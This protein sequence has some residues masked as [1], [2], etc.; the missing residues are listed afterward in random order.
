MARKP[1][2]APPPKAGSSP[3]PRTQKGAPLPAA[4]KVPVKSS[5]PEIAGYEFPEGE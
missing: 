2:N 4:G 5:G 3:A 1:T